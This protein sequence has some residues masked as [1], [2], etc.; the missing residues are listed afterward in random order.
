[1]TYAIWPSITFPDCYQP[2]S[3][4]SFSCVIFL[5]FPLLG[6]PA[7]L[8]FGELLFNNCVL[9]S[10][11]CGSVPWLLSPFH[12]YLLLLCW[13]SFS[14]PYISFPLCFLTA[15]LTKIRNYYTLLSF[16]GFL[17]SLC[18]FKEHTE[19]KSP[20]FHYETSCA[21]YSGCQ[22]GAQPGNELMGIWS[23]FSSS[24]LPSIKLL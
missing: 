15:V 1:M 13:F 17:I 9:V 12:D 10:I 7:L 24:A 16:L 20:S 3:S 5:L 11:I 22:L 21:T 19:D 18:K 4:P 2:F 14:F 23:V 8:Q 6:S